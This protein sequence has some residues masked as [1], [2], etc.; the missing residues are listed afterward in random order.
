MTAFCLSSTSRS[1]PVTFMVFMQRGGDDDV[2]N[3]PEPVPPN[4]IVDTPEDEPA[5]RLPT[6]DPASHPRPDGKHASDQEA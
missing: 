3:V 1:R 6:N 5:D 4:L 2:E